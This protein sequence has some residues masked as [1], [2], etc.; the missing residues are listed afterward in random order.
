MDTVKINKKGT[1]LIAHR[2]LCGIETENTIAAFVAAGNRSYFGIETDVHITADK[3]F[4]IIHDSNTARIS[5]VDMVVEESNFDDLRKLKLYE[6]DT[7]N[8][9][10][11]LCIPSLAEYISVCKKYDKTA[12]LEL[13]YEMSDDILNNI[14]SVIKEAD[15]IEKVIYISFSWEN[16]VRMR[17]LLPTA[18]I[19]FL[20]DVFDEDL[21]QKLNEERIDLDVFFGIVTKEM[22][23]SLHAKGLEVNC[24]TCDDKAEAEKLIDWGIDY[25]TSNI[26]E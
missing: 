21:E 24:W 9:R 11:D 2:G 14:I 7:E 1:K 16:V 18:K 22:I 26:I 3:K 13:K 25:I 15:Y 20:T 10:W 5:G 17:K 12:V 4:A 23:D 8:I 19:Q 6:K